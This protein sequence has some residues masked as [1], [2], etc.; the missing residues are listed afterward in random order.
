M[1][2]YFKP[3]CNCDRS[4]KY[5]VDVESIKKCIVRDVDR[6]FK[7]AEDDL[8]EFIYNNTETIS[9]KY[10]EKL[11]TT[12]MQKIK[13]DADDYIEKYEK[14]IENKKEILKKL[15][16]EKRKLDKENKRLKCDIENIKYKRKEIQENIS[17]M[18]LKRSESIK[19]SV[20]SIDRR[21]DGNYFRVMKTIRSEIEPIVA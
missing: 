6:E 2:S 20:V 4:K 8:N 17:N 9:K 13:N 11:K 15:N 7:D 16:A 18:E 3:P 19:N 1:I 10:Y 5:S 12:F 21:K 14:N